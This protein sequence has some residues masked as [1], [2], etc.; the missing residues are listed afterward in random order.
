MVLVGA[1]KLWRHGELGGGSDVNDLGVS[2][3]MELLAAFTYS[4]INWVE[5]L[6]NQIATD[7]RLTVA[8]IRLLTSCSA[9]HL[10]W[11]D[12]IEGKETGASLQ[13]LALALASIDG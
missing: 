11:R 5:E 4:Q 3:T 12:Y 10:L 2:E 13:A 1:Q 9:G 8:V 6:A 7:T